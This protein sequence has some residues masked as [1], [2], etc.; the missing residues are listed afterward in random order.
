MPS[1]RRRGRPVATRPGDPSEKKAAPTTHIAFRSIPD[2]VSAVITKIHQDL[3]VPK[4]EI[5][6]RFFEH[7]LALYK[8]GRLQIPDPVAWLHGQITLIE[9]NAEIAADNEY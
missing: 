4:G 9:V 7:S 5:A 3:L 2:E 1:G 8:K 6:R